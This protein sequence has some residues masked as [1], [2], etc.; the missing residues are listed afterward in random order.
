MRS[1]WRSKTVDLEVC[2][3]G[4]SPPRRAHLPLL[5]AQGDLPGREHALAF[6]ID[7]G[8]AADELNE[9]LADL[10]A[11]ADRGCIGGEK[12]GVAGKEGRGAIRVARIECC[13]EVERDSLGG[14]YRRPSF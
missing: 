2:T 3:K 13:S 4:A 10:L 7:L 5:G 9:N 1:R 12:A 14:V 6:D 8:I 11:A